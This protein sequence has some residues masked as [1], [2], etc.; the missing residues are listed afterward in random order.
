[1]QSFWVAIEVECVYPIT[2]N[3]YLLFIRKDLICINY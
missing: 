2:L 3:F 1:M